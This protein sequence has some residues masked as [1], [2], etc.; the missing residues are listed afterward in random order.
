MAFRGTVLFYVYQDALQ[1]AV[2]R[3]LLHFFEIHIG[4]TFVLDR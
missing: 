3:K 1:Q 2:F 4:I